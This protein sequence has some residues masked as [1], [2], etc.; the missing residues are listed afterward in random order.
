VAEAARQERARKDAKKPK[1][2]YSDEDL[3][4]E[5]ILTPE[6]QAELEARRKAQP[7]ITPA[8]V[9]PALDANADMPQLPLGDIARRYRNAKLAAQATTP[10]HLPFDEPVFAD[11][12]ISVPEVD[13]P[14]PIFSPAHP[15]FVPARPRTVV[16][17]A[18]SVPAPESSLAPSA[19]L[20][21][22]A[23]PAGS[24]SSSHPNLAPAHPNQL[25]AP[26]LSSAAPVRRV[27]PFAK[28][29]AL[30]APPAISY[31]NPIVAQPRADAIVAAAPKPNA[32]IEVAPTA[33]HPS[34][35]DPVV[36][37]SI[38]TRGNASLRI[39]T[40][41]PGDSLWKLAQENLGR[42]SRWQELLA[43]NPGIVDPAR[44]AAGTEIVLPANRTGMKT[45]MRV[46]VK[47]GD[48]LTQIAKLTYGRAAAWRC[49]EQ[50]NP[51]IS[52]A[53]HIYAG[54]QLRLP[55]ACRP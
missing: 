45:D 10:Y 15:N 18:I 30:T 31:A 55:F 17:P 51:E 14:R 2:V 29:F 49:I 44:I 13:P 42:G 46:T 11:P 32:R 40:V 28:R 8:S 21:R 9:E 22:V 34:S 54:Q 4:R 39:V 33:P 27:D 3:R 16:A 38:E 52:D 47:Q 20:P 48:T 25:A 35:V 7:G 1:H 5:K 26:S 24:Y 19:A 23:R 6:D 41:R 43:A 50:A 36:A 53:N 37:P 12:V